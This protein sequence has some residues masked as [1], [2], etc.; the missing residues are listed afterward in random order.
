MFVAIEGI[1][2]AG[3]TTCA[4]ALKD[5]LRDRG[6]QSYFFRKRGFLV[7]DSY[8]GSMISD[9]NNILWEKGS[10]EDRASVPNGTWFGLL[11]A[12]FRLVDQEIIKP[13]RD[14]IVISDSWVGKIVARFSL[15]SDISP[16]SL[17]ELRGA[18][19]RPD[20]TIFLNAD[21]TVAADRKN[22]FGQAESGTLDGYGPPCR[23]SFIAYQTAV[24]AAYGEL[25][26]DPHC[27]VIDCGERSPEL[28]ATAALNEVE[29]VL[30]DRSP[31]YAGVESS[32][33]A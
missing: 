29:K 4:E 2:G 15:K 12:W 3:K 1:D 17:S 32:S 5:L 9:L 18:V 28:I 25:L 31:L 14:E 19:S 22:G 13:R 26:R 10:A 20:I 27:V 11:S 23:D 33:A 24:A 30:R 8:A 7:P 16:A 6:Y 21:P